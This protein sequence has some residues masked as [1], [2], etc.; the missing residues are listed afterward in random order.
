MSDVPEPIKEMKAESTSQG[1]DHKT[2]VWLVI[3][4]GFWILTL[5][6]L[7]IV[8]WNAFFDEKEVKER[9]AQQVAEACLSGDLSEADQQDLC[10]NAEKVIEDEEDPLVIEGEDGRDGTDGEDG[11]DGI[12]GRDGKDGRN[13]K[14]GRPGQDGL[15]GEDGEGVPGPQGIQGEPGQQG[16][17]GDRGEPGPQGP[18]GVVAIETVGCEGPVIQSLSA[19]YNAETQTITIICN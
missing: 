16:P 7:G 13:G 1:R 19:S 14:N 6:A 15:N 11:R 4:V 10:E 12:D 5:L 18:S 9:L 8:S 3:A 17:K 2:R